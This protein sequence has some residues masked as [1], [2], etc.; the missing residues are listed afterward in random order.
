VDGATDFVVGIYV[1]TKMVDIRMIR[2]WIIHS[3]VALYV[4]IF[5]LHKEHGE[6]L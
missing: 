2:D 4:D 6:I 5:V 1:P 3:Y